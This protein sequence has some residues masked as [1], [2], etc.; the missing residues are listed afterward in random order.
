MKVSVVIP[1]YQRCASVKRALRFL[2]RQTLSPTEY[3][4][5]VVVDGSTDGTAET[6]SAYQPRYPLHVVSQKNRGRAAACNAGIHLAHGEVIILLDDDMEADPELVEEHWNV[7]K[8]ALN[9]AVI[10][11]APICLELGAPP[12]QRYV[13]SKFNE[14][15]S[16]LS[17]PGYVLRLRDVYSGNFSIRRE[18]IIKVNGFDE[19]FQIYGNED[20][21][22]AVCL[23][24]QDVMLV[25]HPGAIAQQ[26]YTKDFAAL[27]RDHIAKG[28]TSV[29]LV[30][31][32]P[33]TLSQLKLAHPEEG[34]RLWRAVRK[35][36]LEASRVLP[37]TPNV[38][39]HL[40][41]FAETSRVPQLD[42]FYPRVLDYFYWLGV[43]QM[44]RDTRLPSNPTVTALP[45]EV[46]V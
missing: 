46:Q 16:R 29:Q 39:I 38:M 28:K 11:A 13:A 36:L 43:A 44:R 27:A 21:D 6:L 40:M 12:T 15:L 45:R 20:L 2:D 17:A 4:V 42:L 23:T 31:K 24:Q 32:H 5:I 26:R 41:R 9:V 37:G 3:E 8:I 7:H 25:Y 30:N 1:T 19:R 34:S 35:T 10:G 22:L 18:T 33:G 14:H